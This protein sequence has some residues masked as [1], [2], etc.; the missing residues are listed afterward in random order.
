MWVISQWLSHLFPAELVVPAS[1]PESVSRAAQEPG[2][3]VGMHVYACDYKCKV[4]H[5][6]KFWG[7]EHSVK[8]PRN[9]TTSKNCFPLG[10]PE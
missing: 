6:A 3:Q 2:K 1:W 10:H 5:D 9:S 7:S 8:H 4:T